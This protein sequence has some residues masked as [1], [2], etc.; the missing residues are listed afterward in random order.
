VAQEQRYLVEVVED[1]EEEP[2][3]WQTPDYYCHKMVEKEVGRKLVEVLEELRLPLPVEQQQQ[4]QQQLQPE[5]RLSSPLVSL[6]R[7]SDLILSRLLVST[8]FHSM[9]IIWQRVK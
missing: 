1:G 5:E 6:W 4:Q 8:A 7:V 2:L 9:P 3:D